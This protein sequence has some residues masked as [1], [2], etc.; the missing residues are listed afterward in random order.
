M[1]QTTT[2]EKLPEIGLSINLRKSVILQTN[3]DNH[4][5]DKYNITKAKDG[6]TVLGCPVGTNEYVNDKLAGM[7]RKYEKS[8]NILGKTTSVNAFPSTQSPHTS[9]VHAPLG[10]LPVMPSSLTS[11]LTGPSLE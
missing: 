5:F 3:D 6:L 2:V 11:R 4:L 1:L 10:T 7:F 8:I 9:P